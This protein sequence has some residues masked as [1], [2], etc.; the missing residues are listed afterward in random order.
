MPIPTSLTFYDSL[1]RFR[2]FQGMSRTEMMQLAGNTKFGF[3]K[4]KAGIDIS[5]AV[6]EITVASPYTFA[7]YLN[8]PEGGVYGFETTEWD[9]IISRTIE[10]TMGLD[11]K[12]KH[13]YTIGTNGVRGD[14]YSSAYTDGQILADR[15]LAQFE[16]EDA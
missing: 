13:L 6:E 3:L 7:R 15:A 11:Y 5:D 8:A 16:K 4:E 10:M 9:G 12:I 14:G 1:L 2:L